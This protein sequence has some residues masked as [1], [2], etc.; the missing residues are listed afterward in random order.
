MQAYDI[1]ALRR[2]YRLAVI[3]QL[4]VPLHQM[5]V[6]QDAAIWWTNFERIMHAYEDL[7]CEE[8]LG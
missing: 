4:M 8:L 1:E 3:D 5:S 2:D 6:K 7:G